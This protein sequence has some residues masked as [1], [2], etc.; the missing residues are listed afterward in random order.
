MPLSSIKLSEWLWQD[1]PTQNYSTVY[2]LVK[3]NAALANFGRCHR[4]QA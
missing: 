3:I 2:R 4:P 1:F